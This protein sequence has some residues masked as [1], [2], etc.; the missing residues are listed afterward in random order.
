MKNT[1]GQLRILSLLVCAGLCFSAGCRRSTG[2]LSR[3][4]QLLHT[5]VTV[6][7]YHTQDRAVLDEC[8]R[9]MERYEDLFSRTREGSDVWRINQAGGKPLEVAEDTAGVLRLAQEYAVYSDGALDVTIAPASGLWDFTAEAPR[10]PDAAALAA[11]AAHVGWQNL[12]IDGTT[13]QLGEEEMAVDLGAVA[14]GYIAD[15]LAAVLR[16][17]GVTSALIN[18]GGNIYALGDKDGADWKIGIRSP[19]DGTALAAT[20]RVQNKSVVTS[21]IYERGFE[22]DGV[23]Y[24]HILDPKTGRPVQNGLASVTIASDSSA[25]GDA[26]ATACF[27]L[28]EEKGI[29]LIRRMPGVQALFIREDGTQTRTEGFPG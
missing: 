6:T 1:T 14:K 10:V 25:E 4:A 11:A 9:Q 23:W 7:V 19:R 3:S 13:V 29:E 5:A 8:F 2:P 27:V 12:F 21:G 28:G 15:R 16:D 24:H 18:L 22:Q 17:N 26:L 20:V